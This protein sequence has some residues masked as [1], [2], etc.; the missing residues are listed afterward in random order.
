MDEVDSVVAIGGV[1]IVVR[2]EAAAFPLPLLLGG[3]VGACGVR[4]TL[5][6]GVFCMCVMPLQRK[7]RCL[8]KIFGSAEGEKRELI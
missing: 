4:L 3:I 1:S 2:F 8:V 6:M 5:K 7:L